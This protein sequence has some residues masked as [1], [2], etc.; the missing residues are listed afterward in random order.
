MPDWIAHVLVAWISCTLLGFKYRQFNSANTVIA[1]I[2]SL[3]PDII[4]VGMPLEWLNIYM[5]N[6]IT[7]LHL[8]IGSVI[9]AS[10]MALFF[11]ERKLVFLFLLFGLLTHYLL[12]IFLINI[13]GGMSLLFPLSWQGFQ[14]GII[15]TDD[16][17]LTFIT[18]IVALMVFAISKIRAKKDQIV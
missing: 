13:S 18:I 11:R 10:I 8:P 6:Y 5:W 2:G 12:D 3:I 17:Y 14:L 15:P 16:Y 1:M 7:P 9:I 4:K